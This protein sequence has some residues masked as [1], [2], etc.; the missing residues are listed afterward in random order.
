MPDRNF[1]SIFLDNA[2]AFADDTIIRYKKEK[3][4]PYKD[5]AW[6]DLAETAVR[7]AAGLSRLGMK[8]GDRVALLSFNR[9]EWIVADLAVLLSGGVG[10]PIYHTCTADQCA[11]ILGDSNARYALA[12]DREQLEKIRS[13]PDAYDRLEKIILIEGDAPAGDEK[14]ISYASVLE[15]G[16]RTA[17]DEREPLITRGRGV[18]PGQLATIVYTSGTTGPPKGCMISHG[19]IVKVLDSIDE[20]HDIQSRENLSL[21]IL[22]L[23][24]F[25]P[26]VS[27]YYFNLYKNI[28]LC[29]AESMDTIAGDMAATR[30]TYFCCVPRILEK[31]YARIISAAEKGSAAQRFIFNHALQVGRAR[32]R[33]QTE[34]KSPTPL[35]KAGFA[36]ADRLV[37]KKIR[38][39]LGGALSFVVSAGAPLS[40]DVGEFVHAIGVRVIE[41][42]GL[43]ETLGGTMTTFEKYRF[44]SVGEAMP[45]FEVKL[46]P[47]GEILIRGNNFMGYF[48]QPELT[49]R[50]LKDGWCYTGDVGR[51]DDGFLVITDRKKDLIITSGGKN[52]SPQNLENSIIN[53]IPVVTNAMVYGDGKKHLTVLL[54]LDRAET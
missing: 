5:L 33:A 31:V 11:F 7:F 21:L 4:G 29:I 24:H 1:V 6:K 37:F 15:K 26:R 53:G 48:N 35:Q 43:T 51:W 30:P 50:T 20:M 54:T 12:E 23:S 46:A 16:A 44:G 18:D 38:A 32:S 22:P 25:Y 42:Y 36:L 52:I 45:G 17:P 9:L 3:G 19:N 49:E 14:I 41:F 34:G 27:G 13:R 2:N 47:D 10:A 28:P 8:S 40:A 39:R